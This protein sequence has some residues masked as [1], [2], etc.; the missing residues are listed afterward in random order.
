MA[1]GNKKMKERVAALLQEATAHEDCPEEFKALAAEWIEKRND[2]D[3]TKRLAGLLKPYIA[4]G[5]EAGCPV[6]AELKT[7]DHY[8]IKS[9]V[10]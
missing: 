9:E 10:T 1:L 2:A 6:C 7:L 4:S 8:L 3:E 5:A